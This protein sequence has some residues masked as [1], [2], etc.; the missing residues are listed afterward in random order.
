VIIVIKLV[1]WTSLALVVYSYLVYPVI[2]S[3]A[4]RIFGRS[5]RTDEAYRPS[6]AVLVPV[7]NEEKVI[8]AKLE[9]ITA[10]R[11]P[12]DR[13]EIWIGSDC[14]TDTT[15]DIVQGFPDN[16]VH[17]WIAPARG[18][19]TEVLNHMIPLV[20]AD[21]L[22]FTDAN[23]MHHPDGVEKLVRSF[24]DPA[25]GGVAGLIK[26]QSR[27]KE[28]AE[29]LYRSFESNQKFL[30]SRLHSSISAFGGFYSIRRKLFKPLPYNAYS[31]DDVLIPMNV[32]RQKY[33][34]VFDPEAVSEEDMTESIAHEFTRRI[35]IGAGNFQAFFWLLD[36][37]NPLRGWPWFCFFSHKVTRWF[38]PFLIGTAFLCGAALGLGDCRSMYGAF[39]LGCVALTAIGLLYRVIPLRVLRPP[40]YFMLMNA[41]LALGFF[42]FCAGIQSAA[43]SRTERDADKL[44]SV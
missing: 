43:W 7:Y 30:E 39:S 23:T 15:H 18:G 26:H 10:L 31:N 13:L 28:L 24:A 38:S 8:R 33:R 42:R 17:L 4:A 27:K 20:R 2:L 19:K 6:I 34:I 36:F 37:L 16:R 11:Y 14:S 32:I 21:I 29:V 12:S 25:V 22:V 5:V 35:R 40:Y 44:R 41:A 1:F 9:N 3:L